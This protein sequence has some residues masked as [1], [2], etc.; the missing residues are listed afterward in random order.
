MVLIDPQKK[1]MIIFEL[2]VPFEQN[3]QR[4]H[5]YKVNKYSALTSD[6]KKKGFKCQLI[7]FEVGSR[8]HLTK[9][10]KGSIR[11]LLKFV[12]KGKQQKQ[13]CQELSKLALV[14][15]YGI[16]NARNEPQWNDVGLLSL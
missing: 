1:D 15:S 13:L 2:T 12:R 14:T 10:N 8:G 5:N 16:Y 11:N 4:S 7:C 6:I 3:V 9:D